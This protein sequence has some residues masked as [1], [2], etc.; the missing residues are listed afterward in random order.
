MTTNKFIG[1]LEAFGRD[2][3]KE[4]PWVAKVAEV[5]VSA[6]FPG[7]SAL[8]NQV[9]NACVSA[10]QNFAAVGQQSG[11]GEQKAAAVTQVVGNLIQQFL[12]ESGS[13]L[14]VAQYIATVVNML[15]ITPPPAALPPATA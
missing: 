5:G 7:A 15:N 12:T 11:T 10:E 13:K 9:A 1:F 4:L 8:F 3:K 14:T 6:F 2:I